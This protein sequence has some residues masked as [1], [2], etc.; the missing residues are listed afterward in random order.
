MLRRVFDRLAKWM[1]GASQTRTLAD[2]AS[3]K[4]GFDCDGRSKKV[5]FVAHCVLN[6]NARDSGAADFPAMMRPILDFLAAKD[7]GVIQLPCP[8]LMAL[9]LGRERDARPRRTLRERLET[10]ASHVRLAS[11]I[12]QVL[13]QIKEY[14]AGGFS[15]VGVLGKNGSPTCGV[16]ARCLPILSGATEGVF[17]RLLRQRLQAEGVGIDIAGI[18]DHSQ[19]HAIEWIA[20]RVRAIS[21]DEHAQW[22]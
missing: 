19:Q 11:L 7:I 1:A 9:G 5:I 4:T 8:E 15:I 17:I 20:K 14:Q 2:P 18:D 21:A 3:A 13:H 22:D 12:D 16:R 6:Q 10:S